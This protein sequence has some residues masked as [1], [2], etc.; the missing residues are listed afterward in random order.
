MVTDCGGA[1]IPSGFVHAERRKRGERVP[2][3][4]FVLSRTPVLLALQKSAFE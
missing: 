1:A 2:P 3:V 4:G